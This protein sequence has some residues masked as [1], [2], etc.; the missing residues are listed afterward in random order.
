MCDDFRVVCDVCARI[1][2][3]IYTTLRYRLYYN[4]II[5]NLYMCGGAGFSYEIVLIHT[6][7]VLAG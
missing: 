4:I 6:A 3:N 2:Y 1:R 5:L 7:A